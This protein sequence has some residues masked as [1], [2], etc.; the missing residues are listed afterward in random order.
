MFTSILISNAVFLTL[1]GFTKHKV[2]FDNV[3][4]YKKLPG[5]DTL[6]ALTEHAMLF[7]TQFAPLLVSLFL[8][9]SREIKELNIGLDVIYYSNIVS[10]ICTTVLLFVHW[11]KGSK[12]YRKVSPC[13]FLTLTL[14]NY[15]VIPIA[16]IA[17]SFT[18]MFSDNYN[19]SDNEY[20]PWFL[21]YNVC[22]ISRIFEFFFFIRPNSLKDGQLLL[23]H[24]AD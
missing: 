22:C 10:T 8:Q 24:L 4:D 16:N 2:Y 1:R 21:F 18:L 14:I 7:E 17:M 12:C 5:T 15:L 19:W 9:Y 11:K 3:A 13:I 6:L 20:A 23:K